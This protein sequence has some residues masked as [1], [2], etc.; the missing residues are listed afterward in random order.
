MVVFIDIVAFPFIEFLKIKLDPS[1]TMHVK[2]EIRDNG[3]VWRSEIEEKIVKWSE[4]C[5]WKA[6]FNVF[7][8][9]TSKEKYLV[10]PFHYFSSQ[11]EST[12]F[13]KLLE[14]NYGKSA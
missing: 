12:K 2:V 6:G 8:L 1:R 13:R 14:S 3:L 11:T 5:K 9:F 7:L 10:I 4:I